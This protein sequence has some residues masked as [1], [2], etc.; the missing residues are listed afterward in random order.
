MML[1]IFVKLRFKVL[2][3]GKSRKPDFVATG[4]SK[5]STGKDA[6]ESRKYKAFFMNSLHCTPPQI[7]IFIDSFPLIGLQGFFFRE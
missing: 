3:F 1:L 2:K 7:T 6:D 5:Q 4:D